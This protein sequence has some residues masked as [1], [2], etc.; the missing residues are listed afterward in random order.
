MLNIGSK[1]IA[2]VNA[3]KMTICGETV[4]IE[5]KELKVYV[6]YINGDR[7]RVADKSGILFPDDFYFS[8]GIWRTA[9]GW[10]LKEDI[11]LLALDSCSQLVA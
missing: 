8:D 3:Q 6:A 9:H 1:V 7:L 10:Y 2:R 5:P 4:Y 11:P